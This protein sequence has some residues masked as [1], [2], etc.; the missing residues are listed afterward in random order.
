MAYIEVI[1]A[2]QINPLTY[3]YY[4]KL[5]ALTHHP[6]HEM[7]GNYVVLRALEDGATEWSWM[8]KDTFEDLFTPIETEVFGNFNNYVGK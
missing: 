1:Q 6:E 4:L 8:D 3:P 7:L 5:P 2:M